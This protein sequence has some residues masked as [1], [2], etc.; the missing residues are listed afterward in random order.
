MGNR[1][2][3]GNSFPGWFMAAFWENH[4]WTRIGFRKD[5]HSNRCHAGSFVSVGAHSW[6]KVIHYPP[7]AFRP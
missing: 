4:E 2:G 7:I 3:S 1:R 6:F 5:D